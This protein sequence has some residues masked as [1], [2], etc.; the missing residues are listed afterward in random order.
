MKKIHILYLSEFATNVAPY[1]NL[2]RADFSIEILS[3][4]ELVMVDNSI[5]GI[6][7][8][9][10][11]T[12]VQITESNQYLKITFWQREEA[13]WISEMPRIPSF[14]F[15]IR[16]AYELESK[17]SFILDSISVKLSKSAPPAKTW[18]EFDTANKSQ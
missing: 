13:E 2:F 7:E 18:D 4:L 3:K 10:P 6:Y 9:I 5:D 1:L 15:P 16:S 14:E 12:P 8:H 17:L 11:V